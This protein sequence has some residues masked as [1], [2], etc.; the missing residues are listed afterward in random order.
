MIQLFSVHDITSSASAMNPEKLLWLNQH[1]LKTFPPEEVAKELEWHMLKKGID[2]EKGPPLKEVVVALR[3]RSKTLVEMADKSKIF[4]EH[5]A[6]TYD[7]ELMNKHFTPEAVNALKALTTRLSKL[8]E[9]KP[10]AIHDAMNAIVEELGIKLGVIAQP[11]R[12]A[13]TGT[14]VSPPVD[15]TL[16]LM[17]KEKTLERLQGALSNS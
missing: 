10:Q 7:K 13:V 11:M 8:P 16:Y 1:Y 2:T 12:I 5:Q 17:G 6:I 9:W 15:V 14:T 3:E 4:Y